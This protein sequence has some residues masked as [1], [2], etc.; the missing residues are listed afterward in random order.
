M[1]MFGFGFPGQGFHSLQLPGPQTSQTDENLGSIQ[2]VSGKA[3]AAWVEEELKHLIDSSWDWKVRQ[4]SDLEYLVVFPNKAMLD[5]LSKFNGVKLAIHN[6]F[7]MV[8]KSNLDA[9][10]SSILQTGWIQIHGIPSLARNEDAVRQIAELAGEV[11]VIDELSLIR[12]GPVRVKI[13]ARKVHKL[14]GFL[15]VFFGK[16]G[17]ELKFV[18]EGGKGKATEPPPTP[19]PPKKPDE[20]SDEDADGSGKENELEWE[21]M[22]RLYEKEKSDKTQEKNK[23]P[24]L[25]NKRCW[26]TKLSCLN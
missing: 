5:T 4:I 2:I 10:A 18:S 24:P 26:E 21:R 9:S 8:S 20:D 13:N 23:Y 6:I 1:R 17:R 15:E 16:V 11:E 22:R 19:P 25:S 7:A 3:S 12:E 14:N